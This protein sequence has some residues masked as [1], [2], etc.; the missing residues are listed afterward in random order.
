VARTFGR[1]DVT[2]PRG[3]IDTLTAGYE[4]VNRRLWILLIPVALD[5]LFWFGPKLS[6]GWLATALPLGTLEAGQRTVLAE[7]LAHFNLAFVLAMYV[8]TVLGKPPYVPVGAEV[9]APVW[10]DVYQLLPGSLVP[11]AVAAVA[12]A[13]LVTS[14]YLGSI[15][16]LVRG[17][18][19]RDGETDRGAALGAPGAAGWLREWLRAWWRII[20][21]HVVGALALGAVALPWLTGVAL[22]MALSAEV[23]GFMV[24]LFQVALL[25]VGLSLFFTLNAVILTDAPPLRAAVM[26]A[27]FFRRHFWSA[28]ALIGLILLISTGFP[29]VWRTLARQPLGLVASILGNAYVGTGLAAASMVFFRDRLSLMRGSKSGNN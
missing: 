29:I 2:R 8:P 3:V 18:G 6:V 13:L 24:L 20:V 27:A 21:L 12:L 9:V 11:A 4:T 22:V 5:L 10:R 25:W 1:A 15:G 14:L 26:S 16:A 7:S 23:G 28:L 17:D 19:K